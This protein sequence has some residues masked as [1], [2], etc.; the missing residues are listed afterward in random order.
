MLGTVYQ[1]TQEGAGSDFG[2]VIVWNRSP[3]A[4]RVGK[5]GTITP[6]YAHRDGAALRFRLS[7][8]LT[9][10]ANGPKPRLG[11]P[12][13][14]AVEAS[15]DI[16]GEYR[17]GPGP[18]GLCDRAHEVVPKRWILRDGRVDLS[19]RN[20][21]SEPRREIPDGSHPYGSGGTQPVEACGGGFRV[22][23]ADRW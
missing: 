22:A 19:I 3:D 20:G 23:Y 17:D 21:P 8:A 2:G 15:F 6:S 12:P 7:R 11:Y 5:T 4:C 13:R 16:S 14:H 18:H 9:L 10:T 1:G